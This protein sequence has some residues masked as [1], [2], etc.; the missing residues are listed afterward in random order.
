MIMTI[1]DLSD[2]EVIMHGFISYIS[3]EIRDQISISIY[4]ILLNKTCSPKSDF[5]GAPAY[6]IVN[7]NDL[8][9][10]IKL[11]NIN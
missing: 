9:T 1:R 4:S 6:V 2:L 7:D 3:R 10:R 5:P 8:G 11:N